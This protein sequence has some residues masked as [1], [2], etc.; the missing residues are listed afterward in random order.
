MIATFNRHKISDSGSVGGLEARLFRKAGLLSSKP[1][2][3]R[4]SLVLA[5]LLALVAAQTEAA[6]QRPRWLAIIAP[7]LVDAV[8]PLVDRR[9]DEGFAVHL[10]TVAN[11]DDWKSQLEWIKSQVGDSPA[12][13]YLLLV[14][15]WF[16]AS[17]NCYVAPALGKQGRMHGKPT[18]FAYTLPKVAGDATIAVGRLPARSPDEL[19]AMIAKIV[20]FEEQKIGPWS[21]RVNL[22]VGHPGGKSV[23]EKKVAETVIQGT[24]G[25]K[26]RSIS[27]MW[28]VRTLVDFPGTPYTVPRDD[29]ANRVAEDLRDGQCFSVYAGHSGAAGFWS[30]GRYV[31]P[32]DTL[33]SLR[34]KHSA[35]VFVTTGC[36]ACQ[37]T[38]TDGQ[39]YLLTGIRNPHGPA[40]CIGPFAESY[41]AHGQLVMDALVKCLAT[42]QLS[43]G[44][45]GFSWLAAQRGI[46]QGPMPPLTFWLYDQADGS[47]GRVPLA[48]QRLEHLEM[49]TLLGD[50]ALRIPAL[51]P[52]LEVAVTRAADAP[53]R[54]RIVIDFP[55][56]FTAGKVY[57]H[58]LDQPAH[59]AQNHSPPTAPQRETILE[60]TAT[61]RRFDRELELP[62]TLAGRHIIVRVYLTSGTRTWLG[63][64]TE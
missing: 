53:K 61:G 30:D 13:T 21:N 24:I 51:P 29:F 62:E 48:D 4:I 17:K 60:F 6:E 32:R 40:A 43:G 26:L 50:P 15:D 45:L 46:A 22:W 64:G 14:G 56:D 57:L 28:N 49:W 36:F 47:R 33:A 54:L 9:R 63:I 12:S 59:R 3:Y 2:H 37:L 44:R 10:R 38:G 42:E 35:G 11:E 19:R 18:D 8:Q 20:R 16:A 1:T 58:C 39:G 41:A 34:I 52:T 27:P 5:G 7:G 23:I 31:M 25:S 55:A